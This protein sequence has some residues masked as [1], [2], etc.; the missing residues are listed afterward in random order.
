MSELGGLG[1]F[2]GVNDNDIENTGRLVEAN[3]NTDMKFTTSKAKDVK[4]TPSVTISSKDVELTTDEASN[5]KNVE[6]TTSGATSS[7]DVE[8]TASE[9]TSSKDIK[10]TI[11]GAIRRVERLG[12]CRL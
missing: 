11:S 1:K 9:S 5:S 10:P 8:P 12:L 3:N 7:K 6:H 2:I 4:F